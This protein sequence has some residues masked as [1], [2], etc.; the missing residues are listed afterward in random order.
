MLDIFSKIKLS[1]KNDKFKILM[2]SDIQ[3]DLD[4]DPRTIPA[5]SKLLDFVNPDLC[6]L[7]GDICDGQVVKGYDNTK[8]YL[9]LFLEPLETKNIPW[10]HI[11]GNHDHDSDLDKNVLN[12][13]YRSYQHCISKTTPKI[14]GTTNYFIPIY[15]N[16]LIAYGLWAIDSN[17]RIEQSGL[18][19]DFDITTVN[20]LET[21]Y[22]FDIIH[23]DQL[24]WYY[25]SS[26]EL[27]QKFNSKIPSTLFCHYAPAEFQYLLNNKEMC[28]TC[29]TTDENLLIA[30]FNSGLFSTI[31]QRKD[32]K[33]IASGH[34]HLDTAC[35][36][37]C[38]IT[39]CLDGCA[40]YKPYGDD[41]TRGGRVIELN[42]KDLDKVNTYMIHYKDIL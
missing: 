4:Y 28:K 35:G 19:I 30:A 29:G 23:F 22:F 25:N 36:Q 32:I 33:C 26:V 39:C 7:G 11:F 16:D 3:E 27:E 2:I 8:K 41:N 38:K 9:D 18:N 37:F 40:G 15:N 13:I 34:S 12:D 6:V 5:I 17:N 14:Y 21:S 1:F 20:R 42:L 24:Q 31:L 10:M